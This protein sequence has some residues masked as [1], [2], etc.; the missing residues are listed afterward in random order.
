MRIPALGGIALLCGIALLSL[1]LTSPV[2]AQGTGT[3]EFGAF[4]QASYF[5]RSLRFQ[6][7]KGGAGA[8]LGFFLSRNFEIE[9][10][11]ALVPTGGPEDTRVYYVP[12]RARLLLNFPA[13]AH[14]AFLVG[15]GYVHNEYR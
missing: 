4:G 12:L 11:G 3:L 13:S 15:G 5:D 14:T 10:E 1:A 8:H 9:A 6:Q 7:G 2:L